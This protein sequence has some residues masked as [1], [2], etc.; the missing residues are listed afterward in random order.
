MTN[1]KLA[2]IFGALAF[3]GFVVKDVVDRNSPQQV[4]QEHRVGVTS[5]SA[6]PRDPTAD[7]NPEERAAA[8]NR[9]DVSCA[10]L[11]AMASDLGLPHGSIYETYRDGRALGICK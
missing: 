7:R 8:V 10:A 4:E 11:H 6:F 2:L 9:G 5:N 3:L 1:Q